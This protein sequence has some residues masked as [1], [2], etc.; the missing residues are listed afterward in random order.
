MNFG[1]FEMRQ[2]PRIKC[3]IA[4][5]FQE[6][7]PPGEQ[8]AARDQLEPWRKCLSWLASN[9]RSSSSMSARNSSGLTHRS[10]PTSLRFTASDTSAV[11]K[12]IESTVSMRRTF[13]F[14]PQ[15]ITR[16]KV[17]DAG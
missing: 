9:A 17:V 5:R 2:R 4:T 8:K 13:V 1:I 14:S 10:S 15:A 3:A 16:G 11:M 7:L 6:R 12:R